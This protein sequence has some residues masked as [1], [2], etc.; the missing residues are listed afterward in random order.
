MVGLF[1]NTL[2]VRVPV[3]AGAAVL[4][5]LRGLQERQ[6]RLREYEFSP[7]AQVQRWSGV[8]GHLFE[9][10]LVFENYPVEQTLEEIPRREF[11]VETVGGLEQTDY[12]LTL[13]AAVVGPDR[14][15]ALI[16]SYGLGRFDR[17]AVERMLGHFQAALAAFAEAPDGRLGDVSLL[18]AGESR[19]LAAGWSGAEHG[20]PY[21]PLVHELVAAQAARTPEAAAVRFRGEA[22]GYA[23]LD[24]RANRLAH[25]L[26]AL[27]VGPETR[28]GVCLERTPELVVALLGVLRAGG[29]YLPLDPAYPAER[30]AL[31]LEDAGA[32]VVVTQ[33]ELA[34]R[35]PSGVAAVA[36]DAD[37][38]AIAARPDTAT[39]S[40]AGPENLSHVIYTSG[41]TGRPKGV[42]IRHASVVVLLHWLRGFVSDEERASALFSTSVSF[43]VSVAELFGTLAWGGTLVMVDNALELAAAGEPVVH[44]SM[45]PT[46]AAELLRAGGIPASVR[47]LALGGEA[48]P[49]DLARALYRLPHVERVLNLYGPTEDTVYSTFSV[50]ERDADR[51]LIGRP[52]PGTRAYVL[53]AELRPSPVGVAG[54]LYLAGDGLARGYLGRPEL[55]AERFVPDPLG[56]PGTRMYRVLDRARRTA[57]GGLEYL[58]R[59]DFQVKVRGFRVEPGEIEAA[60]RTHP[61]VREAVAMARP[62]ADGEPRL[63][64]W[65]VAAEGAEPPAAAELRRHLRERLPEHMVPAFF[66]AL[67]G[68]PLTASG[69]LDRRALPAPEGTLDAREHVAPRTP[70]EE[71]LAEI[72]GGVLGRA[73]VGVHD[74]FFEMGGHSLL[75]TRVISRVRK[76]FG[77][78]L[79][80]RTLF[81]APTVARL[82]ELLAEHQPAVEDVDEWELAAELERLSE[83]SEEEVMRLLRE[84]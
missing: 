12:P 81:E 73:E 71:L 1:I 59:A 72:I 8:E 66:V 69:K 20:Y 14:V 29:A 24:R 9:S 26:R 62:G 37:R 77:V 36:V 21:G 30:L 3:P 76:Q 18:A 48:L 40:G 11:D 60:L 17:D 19:R 28:V 58:G 42:M 32:R 74:D 53:D 79:A 25:H 22:L 64:A 39:E 55:T 70:V 13:T 15:L 47:T 43:D 23:E 61:A 6:A 54:E 57:D 68:L 34:P 38:A 67:D 10:I 35:L 50:V 52:L 31:M 45:V 83:L 4:P 51:V 7:L 78:E 82:A 33:A 84:S 2:P 46:A 49:A 80:L 5:W 41:S 65:T 56:E 27:G 16:A 63:V 75:A 44:A